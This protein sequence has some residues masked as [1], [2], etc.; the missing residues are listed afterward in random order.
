MKKLILILSMV[1]FGFANYSNDK[2]ACY[3][4][5]ITQGNHYY[6]TNSYTVSNGCVTT[7]QGEIICGCYT[8]RNNKFYREK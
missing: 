5:V 2:R 7:E 3:K 1:V 8:I 4:I 6:Y